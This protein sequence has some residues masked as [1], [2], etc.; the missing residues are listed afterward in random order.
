MATH[1]QVLGQNI[2]GHVGRITHEL[3]EYGIDR[4]ELVELDHLCYRV[5]SYARYGEMKRNLAQIAILQGETDVQGRPIAIYRLHDWI[6]SHGWQIPWIELPAPKERSPYPE[7]L[8]H[9]EFVVCG[10][11]R[12]FK[13]RHPGV[14]FDD[15]AM[16]RPINPE[17]G[18]K[19]DRAA[20]K[21]HQLNIGAVVNIER[22]TAPP[23]PIRD[24]HITI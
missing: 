1:E 2:D 23:D 17:L 4:K 19:N 6:E 10:D 21:F 24:R 14:P 15:K 11:L 20:M 18:L 8:E 9:A 12:E 13:D 5:E 7:G 3:A 16:N 22:A